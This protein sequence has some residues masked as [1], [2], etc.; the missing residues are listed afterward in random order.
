M[1]EDSL[2]ES[3]GRKKRRNPV[4][5]AVSVMAHVVT[6]LALVLIP[7]LQTQALPVPPV[8]MSL[9]L[10]EIETLQPVPVF[11]AQPRGHVPAQPSERPVIFNP[12]P[13]EVPRG[14]TYVDEPLN[15]NLH[16]LPFHLGNNTS[17]FLRGSSNGAGESVEL[18]PQPPPPPPPPPPV[19]NARPVRQG[20]T[21]Q[22][23]NLVYQ[24]KP[25][26]PPIAIRTRVHGVVL[27][28]AVISKEGSVES[29]RVI[30]GHPLLT[31]AALDA[32]KQWRYRP[33]TLNGESV[34]VV[35][36]VTV[37]FTLQ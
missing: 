27:L 30:S 11:S 35:T 9:F 15:P 22:A 10:P 18:P 3:Q 4:T 2:F 33:T 16:F 8:N 19:I 34:D 21:V 5:V 25:V 37:T 36:T 24:V 29:L 17:S 32:V 7:L 23:A 31:Q 13:L 26:Y 6:V 1:L 14:I 12:Q 20:G 28:E